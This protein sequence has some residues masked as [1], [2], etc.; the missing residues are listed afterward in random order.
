MKTFALAAAAML[1]LGGVAHAVPTNTNDQDV[2]VAE[3]K[4]PVSRTTQFAVQSRH[5]N[6]TGLPSYEMRSDGLMING[7]L[8]ANG[9]EG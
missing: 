8:P 1:V 6:P 2:K 4:V 3:I 7:L 9:W 5:E